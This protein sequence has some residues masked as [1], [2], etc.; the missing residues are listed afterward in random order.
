M[1]TCRAQFDPKQKNPMLV[2]IGKEEGKGRGGGG[3]DNKGKE[4][5]GEGMKGGG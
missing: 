3:V 4:D 1:S 2:A 5:M